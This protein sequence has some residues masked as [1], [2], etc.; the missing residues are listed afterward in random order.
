[1]K[2]RIPCVRVEADGTVTDGTYEAHVDA[3]GT[4]N[5]RDFCDLDGRRMELPPGAQFL[6]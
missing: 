5:A 6:L 2:A 3:D 1:M 4:W